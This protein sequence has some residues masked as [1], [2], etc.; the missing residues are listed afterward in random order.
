[1]NQLTGSTM[2]AGQKMA[3]IYLVDCLYLTVKQ[4]QQ[5]HSLFVSSGYFT[6]NKNVIYGIITL[7]FWFLLI[8]MIS[9]D[10]K[11]KK[12]RVKNLFTSGRKEKRLL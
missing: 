11:V 12:E 4:Q 5:Q 8:N 7:T 1:M 2:D 9:L 6:E 3:Y 10:F